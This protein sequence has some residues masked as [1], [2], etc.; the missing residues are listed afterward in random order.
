M[1]HDRINKFHT[2]D[3]RKLFLSF[4]ADVKKAAASYDDP[5]YLK[6]QSSLFNEMF[7]AEAG[8]RD[9]LI[10]TEYGK[11]VYVSFMKFISNEKDSTIQAMP[12]FRERQRVFA[13]KISRAF[14]EGSPERLYKLRI[15]FLF[16][17]WVL[18]NWK[19]DANG[20]PMAKR[21]FDSLTRYH[22]IVVERRKR[23]C[24]QSMFLVINRA[25]LFITKVP[26]SHVN[27]LDMIQNSSEGLLTAIDKFSPP[28]KTVWRTTAI[29]RMTLN[30][31]TDYNST[32]VKIPPKDKRI[33]YRYG[34]AKNKQRSGSDKEVLSFINQSFSDVTQDHLDGIVAAASGVSSYDSEMSPYEPSLDNPE[35]ESVDSQIKHT[36]SSCY[37]E[38]SF[39]ERKVVTLKTGY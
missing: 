4:I 22:N 30:M 35:R 13:A 10:K 34:L 5:N 14:K 29:G 1:Q 37:N 8:F 6:T 33:L 31:I 20:Q 9:C 24:E 27:F 23:L 21:Q 17:T 3:D 28:Y 11:S 26:P 2:E 19:R 36:I 39:L 25:K 18:K 7:Q 16:T 12:Y 32:I 38:L 15:N